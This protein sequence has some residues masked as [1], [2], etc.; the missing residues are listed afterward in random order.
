MTIGLPAADSSSLV[1]TV[2][3][4]KTIVDLAND[5]YGRMPV[6]WGR[7]FGGWAE[8]RH[9][10]E[11]QLLR[12]NNIRVLPLAQ[13]TGNV[14]GSMADG[15]ADATGNAEDVINTFG[16][17]YLASQGGK[18]LMFLDV[19]GAPSLSSTYYLGW[20]QTLVAHS[21]AF[22][23]NT[24]TLLP[25]V[26]ATEGDSATWSAIAAAVAQGATCNGA[27]VA[28]WT[29]KQGGCLP[30]PDFNPAPNA[31]IPCDVLLWQYSNDCNGSNGFDCDQINPDATIQ[32]K[33]LAQSVLPAAIAMV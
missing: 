7:Y 2:M 30:L 20:A 27:W 4:G 5:L 3:N 23:G 18:L 21:Q 8:Y 9:L 19:E 12:D 15:S 1:T 22:S 25:C 28:R 11:N 14:S 31:Q 17:A 32:A 29:T 33:V 26:Y 13:Q 6:V 10:K 24:V 16:A